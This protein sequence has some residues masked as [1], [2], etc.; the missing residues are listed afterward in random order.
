MKIHELKPA[1]GSKKEPRR[2]GRGTGSGLGRTAGKGHKG[3][4]AR[5]GAGKGPVFEGGQTPLARRLPKRGFKN[6]PFKVQFSII[7]LAQI[8]ELGLTE[9]TPEIL[10]ERRIIKDMKDGLKILASGELTRPVK[11]V[12]HAFSG[13]AKEKII[14]AGGTVEEL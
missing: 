6:E 7:N 3:Q 11:I 12:A 13:A 5:S 8:E 9:V 4:K 1:A 10:K 2:V 14:A